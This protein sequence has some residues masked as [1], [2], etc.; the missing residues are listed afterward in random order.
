ML[1]LTAVLLLSGCIAKAPAPD[2]DIADAG[3]PDAG[4]RADPRGP[5]PPDRAPSPEPTP[6]PCV[7]A[8]EAC[9]G[10]DDDCD[11]L[12][13]EGMALN[14]VEAASRVVA[15]GEDRLPRSHV[16]LG[17]RADGALAVAFTEPRLDGRPRAMWRTVEVS[18]EV[19]TEAAALEGTDPYHP[20]LRG[21]GADLVTARC[22]AFRSGQSRHA[23]L[24]L[25][26]I[27]PDSGEA[28]AVSGALEPTP[29]NCRMPVPAWNGERL[30]VPWR[31]EG[32]GADYAP[33][34]TVLDGALAGETRALDANAFHRPVIAVGDT[35]SAIAWLARDN[36]MEVELVDVAGDATARIT[37]PDLTSP[38]LRGG[39]ASPR[40]GEAIAHLGADRFVVAGSI[41]YTDGGL[42]AV[43]VGPRGETAR[44]DLDEGTKYGELVAVGLTPNTAAILAHDW[45][46]EV[47][48]A[49]V[50]STTGP[51]SEPTAFHDF[52]ER[53]AALSADD[54]RPAAHVLSSYASVE[55]PVAAR[56]VTLH[57][58]VCGP[59]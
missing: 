19:R 50:V 58:G 20:V 21:A 18:G 29:R 17:R 55:G 32:E 57:L 38:P 27:D 41:N 56:P 23:R 30:L 11:G 39:G 12:I 8:E 6:V 16:D 3:P 46:A 37:V 14:R 51:T 5:P 33:M 34:L 47:L 48:R 9:N 26:R 59:R 4:P 24:E 2:P 13:D 31:A 40:A 10:R 35:L 22:V 36:T 54:D 25:R 44:F 7:P 43:F 53:F 28:L 52:V 1:R 15:D 42:R 45:E 49:F